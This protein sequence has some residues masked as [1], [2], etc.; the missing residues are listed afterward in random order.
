MS[1]MSDCGRE[2]IQAGCTAILTSVPLYKLLKYLVR[3]DGM[4]YYCSCFSSI[5]AVF[6]MGKE[7]FQVSGFFHLAFCMEK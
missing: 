3:T 7:D 6:I 4:C 1:F 5:V 2:A